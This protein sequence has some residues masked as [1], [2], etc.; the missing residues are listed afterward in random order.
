MSSHLNISLDLR[1]SWHVLRVVW[2][3]DQLSLAVVVSLTA[4]LALEGRVAVLAVGVVLVTDLVSSVTRPL[5][6]TLSLLN[7]QLVLADEPGGAVGVQ[8]A[9]RETAEV[10]TAGAADEVG[11]VLAVL[12][13]TALWVM[14]D[15][16][17]TGAA[18]CGRTARVVPAARLALPVGEV[19]PMIIRA[20]IVRLAARVTGGGGRRGC[21]G[22]RGCG[23]G[24][25]GS[26][27]VTL[28]TFSVRPVADR[29]YWGLPPGKEGQDTLRNTVRTCSR[30]PGH[31]MDRTDCLHRDHRRRDTD[32][33]GYTPRTW[34]SLNIT[35]R[36]SNITER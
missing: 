1:T 6:V 7:T 5:G 24:G 11:E 21:G 18:G 35:T 31:R 4:G 22:G 17:L 33:G 29:P 27:R 32:P 23:A 16:I 13:L 34:C 20:V 2:H 30:R 36:Y 28:N 15:V 25:D 19:A 8:A 14:T 10:G 3:A 9:L 26:H 12:V